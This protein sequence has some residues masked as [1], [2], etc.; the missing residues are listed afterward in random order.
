MLHCRQPSFLLSLL[1]VIS[2]GELIMCDV[3]RHLPR[4][5]AGPSLIQCFTQKIYVLPLDCLV[6][7]ID[8]VWGVR[9]PVEHIAKIV[10]EAFHSRS[11][12][13]NCPS[14]ASV[15]CRSQRNTITDTSTTD[16][17]DWV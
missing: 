13:P 14:E 16:N 7:I 4:T 2:C 5:I 9:L 12:E 11:V 6:H 1:T 15:L 8:R 3:V 10:I 17:I